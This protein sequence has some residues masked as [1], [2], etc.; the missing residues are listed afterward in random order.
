MATR[1]ERLFQPGR[2]GRMTLK[3]R[4]V[5]APMGTRY[6]TDTGGI[7]ERQIAFYAERAKGGA[8]LVMVE[9]A[10]V[11]R[12]FAGQYQNVC[13]DNRLYVPSH[14]Q[15]VEAVHSFGAK[16]ALQ[17]FHPGRNVATLAY[18]ELTHGQQPVAPSPIP[19]PGSPIVPRALSIEEIEEL[20]E[21]FT[22]A[23]ERARMAGYDA[24]EVHGAHGHLINQFMSRRINQRT[25]RYGGSVENRVRFAVEIIKRIKE[26]VGGTLAVIFRFTAEETAEG[27]YT[28]EDSKRY[29]QYAE[30]AGADAMH[31]TMGFHHG[32]KDMVDRTICPQ[33]FPQG[34]RVPYAEAIKQVV[35][36]PVIAVGVREPEFAENVLR[37]G[38]ADF[39]AIARGLLADAEW[40]RKA[41]EGRVEDIRKCI[42]C[43]Y[44]L[45]SY[46]AAQVRCAVNV[47]VGRER[48]LIPLK[49][50]ARKKKVLIAGGGPAGMEAARVA[51]Q[52]GH[53]VSL[54]ERLAA[55]GEGQ[56]K[57]AATPPYKDKINWLRDYLVT[58]VEKSNVEIHLATEVTPD[59]IER[60]KPDVL[61]V[62]TGAKPAIPDIPGINNENVV[63]AH[64]VLNNK[65]EI[66]KQK[67]AILG[68]W[69]TGC[70]TA[71]FLAEKA[72]KVWV[73]AR[74]P[75]SDRGRGITE[76]NRLDLLARLRDNKNVTFLNEHDVK[77]IFPNGIAVVDKKSGE[78][79]FLEADKV[80]L[81]RGLT[82]LGELATQLADKVSEVYTIGDALEPRSI[83]SAIY[84]GAEVA[85]KI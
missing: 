29:A 67:V 45:D 30:A 42:S 4:L 38:K 6:A 66:R 62:A 36:V 60:A 56:L 84:E 22:A 27:G 19:V 18:A 34:W 40:P 1:F 76:I 57:L 50:A 15:L 51:A 12:K 26:R 41:A 69:S 64:D 11:D 83:A 53:E 28:L 5:M 16:I 39:I 31:V 72:N 8:G 52:R 20:V 10:A 37:E 21:E 35:K 74:S 46:R 44:C 61:I 7:S 70:E 25:D 65:V 2:I 85:R 78:E 68:G 23:A 32:D 17:I 80:V 48:E 58:Q 33:S 54:Y 73:I 14:N 63:T 13:I 82:P 71:E 77:E 24:V 3:N 75:A 47:S 43:L 79:H 55:L 81:A 49:P 9:S 59:I